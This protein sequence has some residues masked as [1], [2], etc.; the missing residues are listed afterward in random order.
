MKCLCE[1]EISGRS[2]FCPH[3]GTSIDRLS[4][5]SKTLTLAPARATHQL[6]RDDRSDKPRRLS[7]ETTALK[8]EDWA[9]ALPPRYRMMLKSG[10]TADFLL[11]ELSKQLLELRQLL[12]AVVIS[13][14]TELRNRAVERSETYLQNH[15]LSCG[16]RT[17]GAG[18]GTAP[19]CHICQSE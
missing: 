15:C 16:E 13:W 2:R 7:A 9:P 5:E 17:R 10:T 19:L 18:R 11:W 14:P 12:S 1:A 3:C 8:E 4:A 6:A